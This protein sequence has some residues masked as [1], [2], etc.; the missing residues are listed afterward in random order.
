MKK[1]CAL[2]QVRNDNFF[3]KKWIEYYGKELG[4]ENLYIYMDGEDQQI[5]DFCDGVNVTIKKKVYYDSVIKSEKMRIKYLNDRAAELFE[6]YDIVIGTDCD[7]FLIVDPN[8]NTTLREYLS[9]AESPTVSISGLGIDVGQFR[10]REEPIDLNIPLLGQRS[11]GYISTRYTKPNTLLRPARWGSGFHRVKWR[12]FFIGSHLFLFHFGSMDYNILAE[13]NTTNGWSERHFN[14]RTSTITIISESN[15]PVDQDKSWD[16]DTKELREL[17]QRQ[18][19]F[20]APNK[21]SMR[22]RDVVLRI[23]E[24]FFGIV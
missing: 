6:K 24:R 3:L 9:K 19:P 4:R 2:T 10:G 11:Y 22:G 8:I 20:Y 16:A 17:Q 13:R 12:D 14:K 18:R 21:P 5:P 1:I 23:P 7:E 15:L